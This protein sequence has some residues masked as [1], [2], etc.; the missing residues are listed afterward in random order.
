MIVG[1]RS[2]AKSLPNVGALAAYERFGQR[3][4][5]SDSVPLYPRSASPWR[6]S[7]ATVNVGGL[8][9]GM[10][11][12][13]H[14]LAS[15]ERGAG[16][17]LLA[18][19]KDLQAMEAARSLEESEARFD[20]EH[21][22]FAQLPHQL[23]RRGIDAVD[24]ILLDL[25]VSSPQLDDGARGFSFLQDGPLDMRM[26]TSGGMTAAQWLAEVVHGDLARVLREYGEER[27]AGR[28]AGAIL[29]A[30]EHSPLR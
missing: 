15:G 3:L 27:Y 2:G 10:A 20:F 5:T 21:G 18:V 16:G 24:G 22:S 26:D 12:A 19:D 8:G 17:H 29:R 13:A 7:V 9:A 1:V 11:A 28:I 25:G 30:R 14:I 6:H 23:R 4:I